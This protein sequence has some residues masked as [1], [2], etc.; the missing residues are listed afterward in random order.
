M[1]TVTKP[2]GDF[3]NNVDVAD[4][5]KVNSQFNTIYNAVNGNIDETN[6]P[7]L[8]GKNNFTSRSFVNV[9]NN[10]NQS[11]TTNTTTKLNFQTVTTDNLTEFATA[12]SR[13]TAKYAGA[14]VVE[15]QLFTA[16]FS[17]VNTA[18]AYVYKNGVVDSYM[19]NMQMQGGMMIGSAIVQVTAG[20]YLEIYCNPGGNTSPVINSGSI[21]K[22]MNR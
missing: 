8:W 21:A 13:F 11:L 17:T 4:A 1:P 16:G 7:N 5:T 15:V 12:T 20:D 10:A 14:V 22:F 2:Y 19:F 3:T 6:A 18:V 9:Q